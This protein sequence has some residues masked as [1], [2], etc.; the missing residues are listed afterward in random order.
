[1]MMKIT[2]LVINKTARYAFHESAIKIMLYSD[3]G[4][5]EKVLDVNFFHLHSNIKL[6]IYHNDVLSTYILTNIKHMQLK[7]D[8]RI[9]EDMIMK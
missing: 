2:R 9:T 8:A 6:K 3:F 5:K 1:M 4:N 7:S